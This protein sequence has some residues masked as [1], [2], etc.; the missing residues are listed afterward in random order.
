LFA[1]K[2]LIQV[3]KEKMQ[4]TSPYLHTHFP[5]II[6]LETISEKW[7]L[8]IWQYHFS[9]FPMI[10]S[11]KTKFPVGESLIYADILKGEDT[12]RVFTTHL[13]SFKFNKEDYADIEK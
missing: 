4:I 2:N 6:F 13:Q 5:I 7:F 9:K 11:G 1:C 3:A 10:D 8:S 12:L